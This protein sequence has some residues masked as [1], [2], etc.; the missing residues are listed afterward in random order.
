MKD[1]RC[2]SGDGPVMPAM[3]LIQ[4]AASHAGIGPFAGRDRETPQAAAGFYEA[5][6]RPFRPERQRLVA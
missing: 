2:R 3:L 1:D 5:A 4:I 6:G